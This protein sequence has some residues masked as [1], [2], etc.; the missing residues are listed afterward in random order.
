[1]VADADN[2]ADAAAAAASDMLWEGRL[3]AWVESAG[4]EGVE[5]S[6]KLKTECSG[7]QVSS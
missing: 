3:R 2:D 6:D 4:V 1:M 5:V 7:S